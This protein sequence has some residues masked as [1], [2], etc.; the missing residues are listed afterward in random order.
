MQTIITS[1]NKDFNIN[2]L[3]RVKRRVGW[4][5]NNDKLTESIHCTVK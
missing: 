4:R 3:Y 1:D 2:K 5:H